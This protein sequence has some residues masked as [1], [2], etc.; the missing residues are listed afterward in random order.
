MYAV[1]SGKIVPPP[2]AWPAN[3]QQAAAWLAAGW[4]PSR[5][6]LRTRTRA[7]LM[8]YGIEYVEV[9]PRWGLIAAVAGLLALA[10]MMARRRAW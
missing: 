6:N 7:E 5:A 2:E 4:Y 9:T 1:Y 8:A 3:A 10:F